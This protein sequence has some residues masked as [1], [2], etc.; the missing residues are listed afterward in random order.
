ML[1]VY[2]PTE[3]CIDATAH[4]IDGS[5]R[6]SVPIGRPL[7]GYRAYVL[8][9]ALAPVPQGSSASSTSP[10]PGWRGAISDGRRLTAERFVACPFARPERAHV[11]ERRPCPLACR[12]R[13]RLPRPRRDQVKIH[14]LRIEPGE[15]EAALTGEPGVAQAVVLPIR[16]MTARCDS[17]PGS[18]P[19]PVPRSSQR[20][21][22]RR[23]GRARCPTIWCRPPSSSSTSCR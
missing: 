18:W 22:A 4:E 1:D 23:P 10:A 20:P 13:A 14:G 21:A 9:A 17:S 3:A 11:P 16:G 5:E 19:G 12:R 8:D 15:I 6:D 7:A 2:G